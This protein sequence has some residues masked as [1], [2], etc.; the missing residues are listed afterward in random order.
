M[1]LGRI[2]GEHY[3]NPVVSAKFTEV[4]KNKNYCENRHEYIVLAHYAVQSA[5]VREAKDF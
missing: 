2:I 4:Q 3:N 1:S 5:P